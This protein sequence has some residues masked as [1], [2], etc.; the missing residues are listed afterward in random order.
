MKSPKRMHDYLFKIYEILK[1]IEKARDDV[2]FNLDSISPKA[3]GISNTYW[4]ILFGELLRNG[5]IIRETMPLLIWPD[6]SKDVMTRNTERLNL[7]IKGAEFL[8][9]NKTMRIFE[10]DFRTGW[11]PWRK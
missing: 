2:E 4:A 3:L 9:N 10:R 7:T 8:Q 11:H 1:I 5:Y 6:A